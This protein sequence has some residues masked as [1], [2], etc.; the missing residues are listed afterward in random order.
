[1]RHSAAL[2]AVAVVLWLPWSG[3]ES[4][5]FLRA[6]KPVVTPDSGSPPAETPPAA[7]PARVVD[8]Y[9]FYDPSNPD[10]SRLQ[11]IEE[12]TRHLPH[13][14]VGFPDWMRALRE[15]KIAPRQSIS[16][17][18]APEL[19]DLDIIMRNTKE[20]P[21]VRFP[22]L[23]HTQWL[24]CANC[25]PAPF[26]AEKGG[27]AIRMADIFRGQFCGMCHDRVAFIT[28]YSCQ[29]CHSVQTGTNDASKPLRE[30]NK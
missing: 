3:G 8:Q 9:D 5:A 2:V 13:D 14:A 1:M 21:P 15:R 24:A 6:V 28:F 27:N 20:M 30:G 4:H 7:L 10:R 11:R 26:K 23:A 19:L 12:A 29:R 18:P 16:G 22:H 25:H 17:S